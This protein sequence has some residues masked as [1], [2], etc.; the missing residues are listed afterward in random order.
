MPMPMP[1]PH[2]TV[3]HRYLLLAAGGL[4]LLA[5]LDAA[6]L[7]LGVWA[8]VS[9]EF[10]AHLPGRHGILM[11]LGFLGT[12]I[13]L[14]R[15]VALREPWGYAAPACS[16]AG[17]A[18]LA[19]GVPVPFGAVLLV[20]GTV[21]LLLVYAALYRRRKDTTVA[22]E[23]LGALAALAAALLW[24]RIDVPHLLPWLATFVIATIAAERVELARIHL[25]AHSA[26][27][28]LALVLGLIATSTATLLIG[29][30]GARAFGLVQLVIVG[31]LGHHDIARRTVHGSGLPRFSAAAMLLGYGWL[32][33]AGAIWLVAGRPSD[34]TTYDI[35]VHATFLGFAMSMVFAHAPVILPGVVRRPLPYHPAMWALLAV[36]HLGLAIRV[37]GALATNINVWTIGSVVTVIALAVFPPSMIALSAIGGRTRPSPG[38]TPRPASPAHTPTSQESSP[39]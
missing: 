9:G 33:V 20:D 24:M 18:S 29:D 7:R 23:A 3:R 5:G 34:N 10:A 15:A 13:A 6:L 17:G 39:R 38:H 26:D 11:V 14:E 31:W 19:L 12:L 1:M 36:L 8:P 2:D 16:G 35:A 37:V 22:V 32:A 25:P 28:M 30:L 27:I 21:L 4:S